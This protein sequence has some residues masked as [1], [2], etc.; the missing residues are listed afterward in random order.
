MSAKKRRKPERARA[1]GR[2]RAAVQNAPRKKRGVLSVTVQVPDV[3]IADPELEGLTDRNRIEL[4]SLGTRFRATTRPA[5]AVDELAWKKALR[6][7]RPYWSRYEQPYAATAFVYLRTG[8]AVGSRR[9]PEPSDAEREPRARP[10]A[11][12]ESADPVQVERVQLDELGYDSG[13]SYYGRQD[14][15]IW[16]VFNASVDSVVRAATAAAARALVLGS[17]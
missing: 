16:R 8:G 17:H 11:R 13:G 2:A 12:G 1:P 4:G 9:E 6:Q 7:L 3:G 10:R 15:P 5:W 14:G